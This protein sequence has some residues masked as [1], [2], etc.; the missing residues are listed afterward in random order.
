MAAGT[1]PATFGRTDLPICAAGGA[2][3]DTLS[4]IFDTLASDVS[5][6]T[7][8]FGVSSA[9][10]NAYGAGGRLL[11][12]VVQTGD[13]VAT[14]FSVGGIRRIEALQP[15]DG[16]AWGMDDLSFTV[17]V[18]EPAAL[19]LLGIGLLGFGLTRRRRRTA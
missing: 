13:L 3:A 19:S 6:L 5:W 10:F 16:C 14:A 12:S 7:Q 1:C 17:S 8:S 4:I 11:E 18:P 9:T 2:R 15:G